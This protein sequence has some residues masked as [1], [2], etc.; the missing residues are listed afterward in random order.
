MSS[1]PA[2][3]MEPLMDKARSEKSVCSLTAKSQAQPCRTRSFSPG[4]SL[5]A[6]GE[7][8]TY[9]LDVTPFV[10]LLVDGHPHEFTIDVVSAETDHTILQN[11]YV[12]GLLQVITDSSS[13]PTTGKIIKYNAPLYAQTTVTGAAHSGQVNITV[14]ASRSLYAEAQIMSGS[15]KST[16]AIWSQEL[17]Y[18]NTQQYYNN[19][20]NQLM[21]GGNFGNGTSNNTFDYTDLAG[22][23][24][25]RRV[26][27]A[28]NIITFNQEGGNLARP[29]SAE[30][31]V[32]T[33]PTRWTPA[34]DHGQ[35][36]LPGSRAV[37]FAA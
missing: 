12:S 14:S 36:R 6:F 9:F 1:Y 10:P 16:H 4:D 27:A 37:I 19:A 25:T 24:Y 3:P 7:L 2:S 17:S 11:W 35:V 32:E 5:L 23:S 31:S 18:L 13:K 21:T 22:N 29:G 20:S 34:E 15:G 30:V 28:L 8:P 26:N 33:T